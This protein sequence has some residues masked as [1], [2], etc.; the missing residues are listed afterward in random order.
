[1]GS[2]VEKVMS[3]SLILQL[4][5]TSH[6]FSSVWSSFIITPEIGQINQHF[7]VLSLGGLMRLH[8]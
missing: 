7:T 8:I 6:Y 1:M 5:Q 3:L 4:F 2:V